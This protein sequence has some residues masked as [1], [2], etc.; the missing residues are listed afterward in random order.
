MPVENI[1]VNTWVIIALAYKGLC[2]GVERTQYNIILPKDF[3]NVARLV[4]GGQLL[5]LIKNCLKIL[6][7]F[8]HQLFAIFW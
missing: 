4:S 2:F 3:S 1:W 7:A 6:R 8:V 5:R